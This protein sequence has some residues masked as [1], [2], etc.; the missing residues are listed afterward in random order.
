MTTKSN[1]NTAKRLNETSKR[2]WSSYGKQKDKLHTHA[3]DCMR[4]AFDHGNITP[5]LVF[6]S[7]A[8]TAREFKLVTGWAR[9]YF[10]VT[11]SMKDNE[12]NGKL[13]KDR[14]DSDWQFLE[15]NANPFYIDAEKKAAAE[16]KV[17]DVAAI[18]ASLDR[19][20]KKPNQTQGAI[21]LIE[22]I[23]S[24]VLKYLAEAGEAE[25]LDKF[26]KAA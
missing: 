6:V 17:T 5:F 14:V 19:M 15:A 26:S 12:I 1:T 10:P 3:I 2:L 16:S 7:K 8:N 24:A 25:L 21:D 11:I 13:K 18:V 22:K 23:N 9:K 20:E 4:H